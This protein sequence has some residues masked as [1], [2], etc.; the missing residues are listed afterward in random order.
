MR[1]PGKLQE[2]PG[3]PAV[4]TRLV[5]LQRRIG[6]QIGELCCQGG[7]GRRSLGRIDLHTLRGAAASGWRRAQ[8]IVHV[9]GAEPA[10]VG[11]HRLVPPMRK[12]V[13]DKEDIDR[14]FC[15]GCP[16]GVKADKAA[17][18]TGAKS[19]RTIPPMPI[20]IPPLLFQPACTGLICA[21]PGCPA[22]EIDPNLQWL[23]PIQVPAQTPGILTR[24]R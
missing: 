4:R 3:Y 7:A 23:A 11:A 14:S 15:G 9:I 20:E 21:S 6:L 24:A 12:A 17:D 19:S 13:A 5:I 2:N 16:I 1:L 10:I 22:I 18:N 8:Q